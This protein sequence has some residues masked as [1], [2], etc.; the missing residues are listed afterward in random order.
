MTRLHFEKYQGTGNDFVLVDNTKGK[1]NNLTTDQIASVCGRRFGVGADGFI[2]IESHT[3]FPFKMNY[4]NSDGSQSFCGNGARC[5]VAF[6][7]SL[8]LFEKACSFIAIDGVHEAEL[9][10]NGEVRLKMAEI[11]GYE[12]IGND[13][14]IHTG[15]PHYIH[16]KRTDDTKGI[17]EFGKEIRY[18]TR[19]NSEGTNVNMVQ[20][21][22]NKLF[23]ETYERGVED[24]TLS[25]GT[26]V[27]AVALVDGIL[28]GESI[29][30]RIIET[31]GGTLTIDWK[32]NNM[33]F[34]EVFLQGPAV[35]VFEGVI[36]V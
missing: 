12:V 11:N 23:V 24:E 13:Y 27:T 6:A 31:K 2:F 28:N 34:E 21:L 3:E 1:Y 36:N 5:A 26:G 19:F 9:K 17:V 22:E 20:I 29:G 16:Y 8:G 30:R 33:S 32:R 15:S 10:E 4:F 35:K 18:N 25:C 14:F 7:H